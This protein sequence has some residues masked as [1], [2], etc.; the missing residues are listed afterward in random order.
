MKSLHLTL[1]ILLI[2]A[3]LHAQYWKKIDSVFTPSG[4][5]VLN[6]SSPE[7]CDFDGDGDFDLLL[8]NTTSSRVSYFK[9]IGTK[10]NSRFLQDTSL[11]SSIYSHGYV[12]TNSDYPVVCDLN[13]DGVMDLIIGGFNGILY[14]KNVGDS[15]HAVWQ[16]DTTVFAVIDTMIGTDAKP[17]FADLDGD[18]DPDL[19]VGI[20]ES[21]FGG[22]TAGITMGFRNIGTKSNPSFVLDNALVAGIP[23]IGLNAYPILRDLDH[24]GKIDLLFGRDLQTF[25]YYKNTGS[26]SVPA[27]TSNTL[28]S[29]TEATTYW[30]NPSLCDLDGD[31][32]LDLIYGTSDGTLYLYQNVGS[33]SVPQFQYNPA[34]FQVVRI[35]GNGASV[36]L[37]DFDHDGDADMISG[38]WLGKFQ[39]FRNDGTSKSPRFT[40][41]TSTFTS[42]D[43]GSYSTPVFVDID[44]DGD[45]DIVSGALDGKVYCYINNGAGFT[46]NTQ[47]F[48]AIDVGWQSAPAFADLDGDGDQDMIIGGEDADSLRAYRNTGQNAFVLDNSLIAGATSP[49]YGHPTFADIDKDGDMDLII[50]GISGQVKFF[51]NIGT[52]SLQSWQ[53]LDEAFAGV[54]VD[55]NAAPGFADLDGDGMV[56][57]V[58]GEYN[59]NFSLY[60]NLIPTLVR[61]PASGKP[62]SFELSQNFPNPFNPATN[63]QFSIGSFQF[64]TLTVCDVLGREVAYLVNGEMSPGTYST[65]WDASHFPSGVYFYTLRAGNHIETKRMLLLK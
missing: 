28:F 9:N 56:D 53:Q 65:R 49:S 19:I 55:Q 32:D 42:L 54:E 1:L 3:S 30:K 57:L 15:L 29:G 39:Y 48:G 12:G 14:Y 10:T 62:T 41:T 20:G 37:A 58:V 16:K 51:E 40:K 36:S 22:P 45:F 13:G 46:Q 33:T 24:D 2:S 17:A 43:V 34:Y 8:G 4:V 18:G 27:W 35:D 38:D 11:L 7:F 23:D 63:V 6:F 26:A 61:Y 59:G 5:A 21:F 44:G 50:G 52:K 25:V 47:I 60:K 64:V 31:G